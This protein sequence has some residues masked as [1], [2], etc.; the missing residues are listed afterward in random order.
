MSDD[1]TTDESSHRFHTSSSSSSS[2]S[3]S[4]DGDFLVPSLRILCL[5]D[6]LSNAGEL[7]DQLEVLG[8]R[9]YENHSID[10]VYVN[11][12]LLV[13]ASGSPV[14]EKEK[15]TDAYNLS[16]LNRNP[17]RVWWEEQDEEERAHAVPGEEDK[18]SEEPGDDNVPKQRTY[19][20]LDASLLLL[21]Q[22]WNSMPFWGVIGVGTGAAAA[23]ILALLPL[24]SPP[25]HFMIFIRG[26]TILEEKELLV[27]DVFS[28]TCLHLMEASPSQSS[29]RL[30]EQFGGQVVVTGVAED[31]SNKA[32]NVMGKVGTEN[33]RCCFPTRQSVNGSANESLRIL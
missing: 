1:R 12:P 19:V 14:S 29:E 31:F 20:G 27:D 24:E 18:T 16:P 5:H 7:S 32:M 25:P 10:L 3:Q 30:R 23:A 2:H 26:E 11:A 8:E 28:S 33:R 15:D 9:L 22:V 13:K 17:Q 4:K 21:R 6:G